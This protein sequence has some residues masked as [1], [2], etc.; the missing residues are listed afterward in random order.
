MKVSK[1]KIQ[2]PKLS[3][4]EFLLNLNYSGK[5]YHDRLDTYRLLA[6]QQRESCLTE[7]N[8]M[9]MSPHNET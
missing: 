2:T 3:I 1:K 9:P 6:L 7:Q 5:K 4:T 8:S